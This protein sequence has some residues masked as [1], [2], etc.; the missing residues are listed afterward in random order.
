MAQPIVL[1]TGASTGIGKMCAELLAHNGYRVYGTSR[2]PG[3]AEINGVKLLQLDVTNDESVAACVEQLLDAEGRIDVLI[4]N[5]G[6]EMLGTAEETSI[7]ESKWLFEVNFF[8]VQR[9]IKAVLPTM[10]SQGSGKII[11]IGSLAG[12][13]AAPLQSNY[14]ASK[15]AIEGYHEALRHEAAEFGIKVALVEP[16][17]FKTAIDSNAHVA[18]NTLPAY[19]PLRSRVLPVLRQKLSTGPT[20]EWVAETV[21]RVVKANNPPLRHVVGWD[22]LGVR[23]KWIMPTGL[24]EKRI[25]WWF[26]LDDWRSD[27][28]RA[29]PVLVLV[30]IA[31]GLLRAVR[32]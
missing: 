4:N 32:R 29:A 26:E 21:L 12:L 28:K 14:A 23:I 19:E 1:V 22:A 8:G 7:A 27:L 16:G 6:F 5:A 15:H 24:V 30:V 31:F 11:T 2:K 25:R 3:T 9:M 13:G 20:P 18:Q 10:R 17:F